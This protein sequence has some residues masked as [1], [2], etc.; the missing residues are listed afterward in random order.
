MLLYISLFGIFLSLLLLY[1]NARN[2]TPSIYL[3]IYFFLVSLYGVNQ[4]V[5]LW[6][7][8]VFWVSILIT[9]FTF[10]YY[11][12][13][14][15][16][17]LYIRSV[18]IDNARLRKSDAFHLLPALIYLIAA[19]PYIFSPYA[20]KTQ[21]AKAIVADIGFLSQ[22]KFTI[23][24]EWFS[25]A[26]VY[27]SR[28]GL[29]FVYAAY[30][31]IIL[32]HDFRSKHSNS[33][34][35]EEV[36]KNWLVTFL[37]FQFLLLISHFAFLAESF[38]NNS[39]APFSEDILYELSTVGL[40]GLIASP[41]LFPRILYGLPN[42]S[43]S[44]YMPTAIEEAK[45]EDVIKKAPNYDDDYMDYVQTKVDVAMKEHQVYLQKDFNLSQ[46]SVLTQVPTHHLGYYFSNFKQQSFNDYRNEFR[47]R[48]AK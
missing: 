42:M 6:S 22:Y 24:T 7:K 32:F 3:G 20:F 19:L 8:S 31:G 25:G 17:Y 2:Y 40:I 29:V 23:L 33:I 36:V 46:L 1:F 4:Y 30:S 48:Y 35:G 45:N 9:H 10:L 26:A 44:M 15:L 28:P 43:N 38:S 16:S 5:I 27:L 41:F 18:I 21:I 39:F 11:L 14:P 47:V 37:S 12:I 34:A 13:G